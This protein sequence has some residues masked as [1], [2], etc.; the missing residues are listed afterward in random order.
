MDIAVASNAKNKSLC[1]IFIVVIFPQMSEI[2]GSIIQDSEVKRVRTSE[3]G[4]FGEKAA[5][6]FLQ[7]EGYRLVVSN[8]KIPVGRNRKGVAVTGEIDL[9]ALEDETLC[10][11]E[12]KTRSSDEFASPLSAVNIRKQRQITRTARVYRK[13]YNVMG[14]KYRYDVVSVLLQGTKAPK[15]ELTKGFWTDAKFRKKAWSGDYF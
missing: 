15:I 7:K 3:V 5:T 6:E 14:M 13:T 8:F 2:V 10:F 1:V 4:E 11:V 12:V 9:I